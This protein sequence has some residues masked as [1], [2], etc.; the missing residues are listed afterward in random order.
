MKVWKYG[1]SG[2]NGRKVSL[3]GD[4]RW[5]KRKSERFPTEQP[6][7]REGAINIFAIFRSWHFFQLHFSPSFFWKFYTPRCMN[8]ILHL[9]PMSFLETVKWLWPECQI[10]HPANWRIWA[11]SHFIFAITISKIFL[12]FF[13]SLWF[14]LFLICYNN[15]MMFL[16]LLYCRQK[17]FI[18]IWFILHATSFGSWDP[19]SST[20]DTHKITNK[21]NF[22]SVRVIALDSF[23]LQAW[24]SWSW[25][26]CKCVRARIFQVRT[27]CHCLQP[28]YLST[29]LS[30]HSSIVCF[31]L[32]I[33]INICNCQ[34]FFPFHFQ[35][36][37]LDQNL[38]PQK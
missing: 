21:E 2:Q 9:A 5:S 13:S 19:S 35:L 25:D 23:S 3:P 14:L 11:L 8:R 27:R 36:F 17:A 38:L 4:N 24:I 26:K 30:F 31:L 7:I 37:G 20:D 6:P 22:K 34:S 15:F 16:S 32:S 10:D 1:L 33:S 18:W 28:L 12:I 29:T